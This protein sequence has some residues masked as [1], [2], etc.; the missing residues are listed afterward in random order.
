MDTFL[1]IVDQIEKKFELTNVDEYIQKFYSE[2]YEDEDL[3]DEF[4]STR[5]KEIELIGQFIAI[6]IAIVSVRSLPKICASNV[7]YLHNIR[8]GLKWKIYNH[9]K[10]DGCWERINPDYYF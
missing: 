2:I 5:K 6:Q 4:Y 1:E 9:L 3:L 10:F 7:D 8:E